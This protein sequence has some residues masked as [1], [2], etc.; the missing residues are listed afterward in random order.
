[1][2]KPH[3]QAVSAFYR[4]KDLNYFPYC[5]ICYC[6]PNVSL[7]SR[8]YNN[9]YPNSWDTKEVYII[10]N[11]ITCVTS[12]RSQTLIQLQNN[13]THRFSLFDRSVVRHFFSQ[14]EIRQSSILGPILFCL[15]MKDFT[16]SFLLCLFAVTYID[17]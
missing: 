9:N 2:S 6:Q 17:F 12:S 13:V 10:S 7:K 3:W 15:H 1:M 16:N 5:G 8:Q 4:L 11:D 14:T